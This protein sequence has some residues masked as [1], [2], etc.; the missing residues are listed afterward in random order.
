M[1]IICL[2][3]KTLKHQENTTMTGAIEG[4]P[5]AKVSNTTGTGKQRN[6]SL[7]YHVALFPPNS[8]SFSFSGR[9][10]ENNLSYRAVL[11]ILSLVVIGVSSPK[12][13]TKM[14][15]W[16]FLC[17]TNGFFGLITGVS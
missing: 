9:S 16:F 3:F 8:K 17:I 12:Y 11:I 14:A 7:V 15:V 13:D 10:D 5:E 4:R 1:L 2:F 6:A